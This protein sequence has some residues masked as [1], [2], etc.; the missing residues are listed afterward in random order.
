MGHFGVIWCT[1]GDGG[2]DGGVPTTLPS[3]QIPRPSH[4][5][6]RLNREPD[7][8]RKPTLL[9]PHQ[10]K[11]CLGNANH[12]HGNVHFRVGLSTGGSSRDH[13]FRLLRHAHFVTK[14]LHFCFT[15]LTKSGPGVPG[16]RKGNSG[17]LS[18]PPDTLPIEPPTL[19][20]TLPNVYCFET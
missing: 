2:G 10:P 9:E 8:A 7:K 13:N 16:H 19:K 14:I 20:C 11:V 15:Q 18:Y 4:S 1:D 6:H 17:E 5:E 3:G 12:R